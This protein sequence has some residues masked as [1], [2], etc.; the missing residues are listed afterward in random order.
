MDNI[1]EEGLREAYLVL[2]I[3]PCTSSFLQPIPGGVGGLMSMVL[4]GQLV[5]G[6]SA[7]S[8]HAEGSAMGKGPVVLWIPT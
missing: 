7:M 5:P 8:V 4:G 2:M 6:M 1:F 3:V